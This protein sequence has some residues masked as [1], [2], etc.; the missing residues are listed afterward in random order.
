[1]FVSKSGGVSMSNDIVIQM[2]EVYGT[3]MYYPVSDTAKA[4][5]RIA[6]TKTLTAQVLSEAST[7]GLNVKQVVIG[8]QGFPV[9]NI[10]EVQTS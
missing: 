6:G 4:L 1:M 8:G 2:R 10:E 9:I 5:A 7:L 3:V